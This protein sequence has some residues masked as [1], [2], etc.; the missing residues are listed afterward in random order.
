MYVNTYNTGIERTITDLLYNYFHN[1][2]LVYSAGD[3]IYAQAPKV[4]NITTQMKSSIIEVANYIIGEEI[5]ANLYGIHPIY[6]TETMSPSWKVDSLLCA[7]YFSVFYLKP[8]LEL[9]RPC[10][11]PRCGKYFLVKTTSTRNR[12]CST[13]CCNRVTQDRYRKKRREL[14]EN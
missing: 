10:D 5:N 8:G 7:A 13:E 14:S 6:N 2:G 3:K 12:Y 1:V 11:N 9:Y 4:E